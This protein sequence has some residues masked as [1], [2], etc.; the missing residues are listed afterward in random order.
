MKVTFK[1][2]I[3]PEYLLPAMRVTQG[4]DMYEN[5]LPTKETWLK[6]L[7]S[8]HSSDRSIVYRIYC[9][10]VP[11]YTHVH[12]IRHH[13]GFQPHVM[14]QRHDKEREDRP[15][16]ALVDMFFD[17]N[18]QALINI[19]RKRL[20][21]KAD[22]TAQDLVEKM[23]WSLVYEGDEYD[24]VLGLL[25]ARPCSWYPGY[26]AEPHPCGRIVGVRSL[27]DLHKHILDEVK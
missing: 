7:L 25:L 18:A 11:Y 15:Q 16:G 19:A 26:C 3:G 1:R 13:I 17:A 14:S 2:L 8:E 10:D 27:F 12:I 4:K 22:K 6:M 24:K 20:C 5:K 9:E 23:K 21:Y